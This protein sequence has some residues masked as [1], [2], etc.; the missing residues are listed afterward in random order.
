MRRLSE[1]MTTTR[2]LLATEYTTRLLLICALALPLVLSSCQ[3]NP[4]KPQTDGQTTSQTNDLPDFGKDPATESEYV[5]VLLSNGMVL[6]GKLHGLGSPY[7]VLTEVYYVQTVTDPGTQK[8]T[9]VLV[10]RGKE[11]HAPDRTI[12]M[13]SQIL[14]I[15]PV[16]KDSKVR[17]LIEADKSK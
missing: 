6:F 9:S 11:W 17:Q 7:P 1:T 5:T 13:A 3:S 8:P 15:E 4:A 10:K 14:L 2:R 16:T 12:L